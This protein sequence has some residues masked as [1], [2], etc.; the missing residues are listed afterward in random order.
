MFKCPHCKKIDSVNAGL[1]KNKSGFVQKH[2]CK[3]CGKYFVQ[4]NG[5]EKM[6]TKPEIIICALDLR[7]KGMSLGK[8]KDH[9]YLTYKI[10]VSTSN[11]LYWQ[12]KFGKMINNFTKSFQLSHSFHA[13]AD[14]IFLKTKGQKQLNFTYY[15]DI[16][17]YETKFLF[18]EHVSLE[19][20][21][22]EG[23][24]FMKKAKSNLKELPKVI[25]T[26]NSYDYLTAIKK[27]FGWR[28]VLHL[29]YPA[30]KHKFKN[31]PIERYHNTLR[32]GYKVMR[33]LGNFESAKRYLAFFRNYYNFL[34][35]H[36]T[37][38]GLTPAQKAGFGYY[39]WWTLIKSRF[40]ASVGID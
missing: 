8:I 29:H 32:E 26:D 19:R 18:A 20:N 28:K 17:D 13:H 25:H 6:K 4:R 22:T 11:I 40:V 35:P 14:E 37:L 27:V 3:N 15:W 34:R 2:L 21:E 30:W 23:R 31:N 38:G 9:L 5:F 1:R 39:N 36:K 12:T 16:I 7:A 10:K 33:K 24:E